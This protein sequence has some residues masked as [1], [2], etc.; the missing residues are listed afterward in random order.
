M[1]IMGHVV[2][3]WELEQTARGHR[4]FGSNSPFQRPPNYAVL[5]SLLAGLLFAASSTSQAGIIKAASPSLDSVTAAIASAVD[6]DT[7]V[8][9]AGTASWTSQITVTKGITIQGQTTTDS[10]KGTANDQTV[11]VDNLASVPGDQ[12]F[13]R[14]G[15]YGGQS[16]RITGITFTGVGGRTTGTYSKGAISVG[17]TSTQ[18]RIDHCHFIALKHSPSIHIYVPSGVADHNVWNN[19]ASTCF[20]FT[21]D[22]G[23]VP[24][25]DQAFAQPAGWGSSAFFFVEDCY[26]DN[27]NNGA[28]NGGGGMDATYGGKYVVRHCY[29]RDIEILCH[30]TEDNRVRGGRAQEIYN[31]EY[32]MDYSTT[33]DGI[34]SGSLITHDNTYFGTAPNGYGMQ[35]YRMFHKYAGAP[36]LGASGDNNWDVNVTEADGITHIDGHA[37]YLF[38]SGTV[39]SGSEDVINGLNY[40][41]DTSKN[42]KPNQWAGYTA[43]DVASNYIGEII[44]NTNNTLTMYYYSADGTQSPTWRSP[45][46]YQIH[47]A[48]IALDQPGRGQGDL[49]TGDTPLNSTTGTVAWPHQALEPCYAWNNIALPGN[50]HINFGPSPTSERTLISGRDYYNDTQLPGYTPYTYPHPLTVSAGSGLAA[51]QDLRVMP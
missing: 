8:I 17:G 47:R 10:A 41:T 13:F 1:D 28:H 37:P 23:G 21:F 48:L 35:T 49:I 15:A 39:T 5:S 36:W 6:G 4:L 20:S 12:G 29:L 32:H 18:V 14:C 46:Q 38:E 25:G 3:C 43:K 42:W 30:G 16:L 7:V 24:Y 11:L 2:N 31:N 22:N 26:L 50:Q 45:M 40:L 51:P 34:R 44:S 27:S 33:L 9:P 19:T